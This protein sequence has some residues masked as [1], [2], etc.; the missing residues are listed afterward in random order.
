MIGL[1]LNMLGFE[2]DSITKFNCILIQELSNIC[3]WHS[4]YISNL[5][6]YSVNG[7]Y[8]EYS[9]QHFLK[10]AINGVEYPIHL[11]FISVVLLCLILSDFGV[12]RKKSFCPLSSINYS[13]FSEI[14]EE[15]NSV[16]KEDSN[17]KTKGNLFRLY[18]CRI[19]KTCG[20]VHDSILRLRRV[21]DDSWDIS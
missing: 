11:E 6:I 20:H 4:F 14:L 16:E 13:S 5:W 12:F 8:A 18:T 10:F 19:L 15:L 3:S 17:K 9:Q 2:K 1:L 21:S 7:I